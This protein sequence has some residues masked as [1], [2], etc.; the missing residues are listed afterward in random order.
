MRATLAILLLALLSALPARAQLPAKDLDTVGIS[1]PDGAALKLDR[2]F[3][4]ETGGETTIGK[5]L[6]GKPVLL[7]FADY[8]CRT[9]CG[10]TIAM[11]SDALANSG[12]DPADYR[13]LVIGM[14]AKDQPADAA[15]MKAKYLED[16]MVGR[17]S[18]FLLGSDADI[19]AVTR[20]LGYR[21]VYDPDADQYAHPTAAFVLSPDGR[22]TQLLTAIGLSAETVRLALVEAGKG[23]IGSFADTVRLL[24]YCY[25][26]ATGKYSSAIHGWLQGLGFATVGLMALGIFLLARRGRHCP[27]AGGA[28]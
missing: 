21:Y 5:A 20:A 9:L 16:G 4:T 15:A 28:A 13:M 7:V 12:L 18:R 23:R 17:E 1:V 22:A 26:P 19:E 8:T 3:R 27:S 10:T 2:K 6:G 14:D 25:D 24:C 11:A